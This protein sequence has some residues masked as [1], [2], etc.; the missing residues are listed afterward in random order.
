MQ[1][2]RQDHDRDHLE[3]LRSPRRPE[4]RAQI[5]DMIHQQTPPAFQQIHGEE[6]RAARRVFAAI[7]R[8]TA[9]CQR[10]RAR[11]IGKPRTERRSSPQR[12][13]HSR[14]VR[15]GAPYKKIPGGLGRAPARRLYELQAFKPGPAAMTD[16]LTRTRSVSQAHVGAGARADAPTLARS[17]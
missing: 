2:L 17:V 15:R 11:D 16:R 13:N 10:N 9:A 12:M 4:R 6:E 3:R 1:M 14:K 8:H 7:T 5:I